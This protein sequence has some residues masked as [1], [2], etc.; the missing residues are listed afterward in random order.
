MPPANE[1]NCFDPYSR[2]LLLMTFQDF[3]L[4]RCRCVAN[5]E[6]I[7][8][9]KD[10]DYVFPTTKILFG[11]DSMQLCPSMIRSKQ[12]TRICQM[13]CH[14]LS[15]RDPFLLHFRVCLPT[16][17]SHRILYPTVSLLKI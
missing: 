4:S 11:P 8:Y 9:A 17:K 3:F 14:R 2:Y 13:H 6:S 10:R 12:P 5:A 1:W 7:L 15:W 16:D